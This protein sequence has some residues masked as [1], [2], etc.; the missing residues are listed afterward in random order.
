MRLIVFKE[1]LQFD[2]SNKKFNFNEFLINLMMSSSVSLKLNERKFVFKNQLF[3]LL[4]LE[5]RL[6]FAPA[7]L[8]DF[9]KKNFN[10]F[11][12]FLIILMKSSSNFLK[13]KIK[14]YESRK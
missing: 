2:S 14:K 3:S 7:S 9:S 1:M 8:L 6:F 13:I 12:E 5:K 10:E 11:N 4:W